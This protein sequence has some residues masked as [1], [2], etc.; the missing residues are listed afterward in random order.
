MNV[1]FTSDAPLDD[2]SGIAISFDGKEGSGFL[3][4]NPTKLNRLVFYT[5]LNL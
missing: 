5:W 1:D 4:P 3:S 2:I